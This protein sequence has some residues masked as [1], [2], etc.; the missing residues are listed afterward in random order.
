MAVGIPRLRAAARPASRVRPDVNVTPLVDV[1]LVLL[2]IFMVIM[3]ELE[4]G[5]R[6]EL[7]GVTHPD[8]DRE[9]DPD[10]VTVTVSGDDTLFIQDEQV[11]R[12]ELAP[13]LKKMRADKPARRLL[14][15][16]DES[17]PYGEMRELFKE[18]QSAGWTGV[19]L[20]VGARESRAAPKLEE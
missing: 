14:L 13:R 18:I 9:P 20:V 1:V 11:P 16:G 15:K 17:R 5:T 2:I 6:V 3:P 19:R 12:A 7:P 10:D 4:H 8:P